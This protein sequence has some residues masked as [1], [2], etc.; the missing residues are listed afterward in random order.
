MTSCDIIIIDLC[1]VTEQ[2]RTQCSWASRNT[3]RKDRRNNSRRNLCGQPPSPQAL[4]ALLLELKRRRASM[5][6][7]V[8]RLQPNKNPDVSLLSFFLSFFLSQNVFFPVIVWKLTLSPAPKCFE[9]IPS[10]PE[11]FLQR[12]HELQRHEM[13]LVW[14]PLTV[15]LFIVRISDFLET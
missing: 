14:R 3:A 11:A 2:K 1:S 9:P 6:R 5:A 10:T 12:C 7:N 13:W 15:G 4:S 8:P